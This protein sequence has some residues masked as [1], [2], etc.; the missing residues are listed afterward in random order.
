M[1]K[2]FDTTGA[3]WTSLLVISV[4]FACFILP[5]LPI[6]W[7]KALFRIVYSILYFTAIF[8]LQK[9]SKYLVSLFIVTLMLEWISNI[10]DLEVLMIISKA[11]NILFFLVIVIT[12]IKQ[13]ATAREVTANVILGSVAGYLLLGI[14]YSIFISIIIHNDPEAF[15]INQSNLHQPEGEVSISLPL[16]WGFITM[17][18]VGFG[19]ILPL[20]PY[21]RS[22]ATFI[23]VSGQFYM[24]IIVAMLVGKF[25]SQNDLNKPAGKLAK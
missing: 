6:T 10:F 19:D 24:A 20:K 12:L 3:L 18:T 11:V 21:T 1:K 22:L 13:I 9:R 2:I 17:T 23:A 5:V 25:A 7:Y 16:Y 4:I 15:N 8:S 14:I